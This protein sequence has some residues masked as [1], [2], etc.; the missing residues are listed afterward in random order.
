MCDSDSSNEHKLPYSLSALEDYIEK[1]GL[2]KI[3]LLGQLVVTV[4]NQLT[5]PMTELQSLLKNVRFK[6][7]KRDHKLIDYDRHRI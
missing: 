3:E 4:E 6:I 5:K 2:A 7:S 1:L